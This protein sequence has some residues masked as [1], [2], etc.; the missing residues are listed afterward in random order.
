[1]SGSL[2]HLSKGLATAFSLQSAASAMTTELQ[3]ILQSYIDK[4]TPSTEA[5][6]S[7]LHDELV[8]V[9]RNQFVDSKI[10]L[11]IS[12]LKMLKK[13]FILA[14]EQLRIWWDLLLR[15][16]MV[17]TGQKK[18]TIRHAEEICLESLILRDEDDQEFKVKHAAAE[19]LKICI[20]SAYFEAVRIEPSKEPE[21]LQN[22][23]VAFARRRTKDF[24]HTIDPFLQNPLR[25]LHCLTLLSKFVRLQTQYIYQICETPLFDSLCL[26]LEQDT[27]TTVVSLALTILIMILPHVPDVLCAMLSRLFQIFG[28]VLCWDKLGAVQ[29]R[30]TTSANSET[31]E[32]ADYTYEEKKEPNQA[33]EEGRWHVLDASFDIAGSTP[34][35]CS[36]YFTFLYGLYPLNFLE[37]LR[38]PTNYLA[39]HRI[40]QQAFE[41]VIDDETIRVRALPLI[42]RHLLHPY[43]TSLTIDTEVSDLSRWK[44][45]EA[46]EIVMLCISLDTT[47]A[48]IG[49]DYSQRGKRVAV[50]D[51]DVE[52]LDLEN[53]AYPASD[54]IL[55]LSRF[56]KDSSDL[57]SPILDGLY[58]E[59]PVE[60]SQ[61]GSTEHHDPSISSRL[62]S[63]A[64]PPLM[65]DASKRF[66]A[67]LS[68]NNSLNRQVTPSAMDFVRVHE[69]LM[70]LK[71]QP[72]TP[73]GG[74]LESPSRETK[75]RETDPHYQRELLLLRNEL[76]F[77][78]H[79]RQ[80]QLLHIGHLQRE[81]ISDAAV[82]TERQNLYNT[83]KALK[84]QVS[85]LQTTLQRLRR[86]IST[87]KANRTR[88]EATLNDR[89][90]DLKEENA[91][92]S[93]N[94]ASYKKSVKAAEDEILSMR[95]SLG[96]AQGAAFNLEQQLRVLQPEI[97]AAKDVQKNF[98]MLTQRARAAEIQALQLKMEKERVEELR[99]RLEAMRISMNALQA[100]YD[101]VVDREVSAREEHGK[102]LSAPLAIVRDEES[103]VVQYKNMLEHKLLRQQE[104]YSALEKRHTEIRNEL[105]IAKD[106]ISEH[107][108]TMA[109]K[110]LS[111]KHQQGL[112]KSGA[113]KAPL[114]ISATLKSQSSNMGKTDS[115][116]LQSPSTS[117]Q[118]EPINTTHSK[119]SNSPQPIV[120]GA[121][122]TDLPLAHVE[123]GNKKEA[124][125]G[126]GRKGE[127]IGSSASSLAESSSKS[128]SKRESKNLL[129][130]RFRW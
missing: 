55:N 68:R 21:N 102:A 32:D 52:A 103:K 41:D 91:K 114:A 129:G 70:K 18:E 79:L 54:T 43:L 108:A 36:Q 126:R 61:R 50:Q 11:F 58:E 80:Q 89:I 127:E 1:M 104:Q 101:E 85:G 63:P 31:V 76:N 116:A 12:V 44:K 106:K 81:V 59:T 27:S 112:Q 22:L 125:R 51:R 90:R 113:G 14:P 30:M 26:S 35:K 25:R 82:E 124:G 6:R 95:T 105:R 40:V 33:S 42:R 56:D 99:S 72:K 8:S 128:E 96:V 92:L 86:E 97:K 65:L 10:G 94:E 57:N 20:F 123:D 100:S 83:T 78:R 5:D 2:S 75:G 29:R 37:Y 9:Y 98:E 87:S 19:V 24:F 130:G 121:R 84:S 17:D 23:L 119:R 66:E 4:H 88:Y 115:E 109:Y 118:P 64:F 62:A 69:D 107:E 34:P 28:R 73:A 15:R 39:S 110:S 117:L 71:L 111:E 46:S 48:A 74:A 47:N 93:E 122:R 53:D 120:H 7:R 38:M 60:E 13:E 16:I 49:M 77:E 3:L 45:L 67:A